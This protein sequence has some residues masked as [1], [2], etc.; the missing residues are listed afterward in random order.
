MVVLRGRACRSIHGP[1]NGVAHS[2]HGQLFCPSGELAW[3]SNVLAHAMTAISTI[4]DF[5]NYV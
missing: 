3:R 5:L 1:A 4:I 2:A